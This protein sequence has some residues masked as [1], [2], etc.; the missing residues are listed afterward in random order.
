MITKQQLLAQLN[1]TYVTAKPSATH[2]IGVFAITHIPKGCREMFT[3][4]Q[5]EWIELTYEE[6]NALPPYTKQLIETYCLFS[7]KVYYVP[8]QGLKVMDLSFYLNHSNTP[9]IISINDG[10]FF[11]ALRDINIG[12]ELFINYGEIVDSEE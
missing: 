2:G 6:V 5:G 1:Q 4:E 11:E 3:H 10:E 9:N 8:A 12:E 7:D